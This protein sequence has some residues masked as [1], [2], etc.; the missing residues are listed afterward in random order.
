MKRLINL[1]ERSK[2]CKVC[3]YRKDSLIYDICKDCMECWEGGVNRFK[4]K[5]KNGGRKC[6]NMQA[7]TKD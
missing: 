3:I 4:Y 5:N 2:K 7:I 1:K 6:L